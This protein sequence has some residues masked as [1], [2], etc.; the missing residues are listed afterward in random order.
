MELDFQSYA[1]IFFILLMLYFL[2]KNKNKIQLQKIAFP[3]LYFA[4]YKTQLGIVFMDKVAKKIPRLLKWIAYAGIAIGFLGMGFIGYSLIA[5]LVKM[6]TTPAAI[7]GV[8]LVLPF[9]VKGSFYVPF[10]Y[11]II[12]IFVLAVVHEFSHGL[13]AR[14]YDVKVKSSGFAFLGIIFPVVPAAFVEPDEKELE[15]KSTAAKLSVFAAGPF[16]NILFA[17]VVALI[18]WLVFTPLATAI[19]IPNGVQVAGYVPGENVTFPAEMVNMTQGDIILKIN[20]VAVTAIENFTIALNNT[21]P[22]QQ[23]TVETNR[24]SYS[25]T[26]AEDPEQVNK[27]YLGV[28]VKQQTKVSDDF[29]GKYGKILTTSIIWI[30]GL[31][32]W[33]YVLN[34]GIGLFNLVPLGPIDGGRMLLVLLKKYLREDLAIKVWKFISL[35]FLFVIIASLFFAF[36]Q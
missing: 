18:F 12:S 1:A 8:A 7:S 29:T 2:I 33:L 20:G 5:N 4:M 25:V 13:M 27:S 35:A 26:L 3:F 15:K 32:Y 30:I 21:K 11:W 14:V 9:K 10:F 22:G 34:L 24:T 17:T 6:L 36:L 16:S 28:Y 19:F 31:F 23:I